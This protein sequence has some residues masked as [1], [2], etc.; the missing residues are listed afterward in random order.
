MKILID[1][2][3]ILFIFKPGADLNRQPVK[4]ILSMPTTEVKSYNDLSILIRISANDSLIRIP[5]PT[6]LSYRF[7]YKSKKNVYDLS[8][9]VEKLV[10]NSYKKSGLRTEV[11]DHNLPCYDSLGNE[12]RDTLSANNELTYLKNITPYFYFKKAKYR[13]RAELIIPI[14]D[15]GVHTIFSDWVYFNVLPLNIEYGH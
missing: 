1:I 3:L 4:L 9:E 11:A 15:K 7:D 5:L 12:S 14:K 8:F 2:F 13:V 10:A 6:C